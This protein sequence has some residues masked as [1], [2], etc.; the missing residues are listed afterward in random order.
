MIK[1]CQ[2]LRPGTIPAGRIDEFNDCYKAKEAVQ[3]ADRCKLSA[4][5]SLLI[6]HISKNILDKQADRPMPTLTNCPG[7]LATTCLHL[8]MRQRLSQCHQISEKIPPAVG[9]DE[10]SAAT[11]GHRRTEHPDR[12]RTSENG[13]H[14]GH[15]ATASLFFNIVTG[16]L[17]LSLLS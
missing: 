16:F 17:L 6:A 12:C 9:F 8:R 5:V 10:Q 2:K 1:P 7:R 4:S 11:V 15:L 3:M 13:K 14:T